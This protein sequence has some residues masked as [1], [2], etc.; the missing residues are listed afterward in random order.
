LSDLPQVRKEN[1]MSHPF[2]VRH[3]DFS[4]HMFE[5]DT[6]PVDGGAFADLFKAMWSSENKLVAMKMMRFTDLED[7]V[8]RVSN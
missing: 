2:G 3:M 1:D 8:R 5:R 7:T 4:P 6:Y